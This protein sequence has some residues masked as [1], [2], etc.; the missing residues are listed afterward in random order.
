MSYAAMDWAQTEAP[1]TGMSKSTDRLVLIRLA[2]YFSEKTQVCW[3]S[4]G[5]LAIDL[6]LDKKTIRRALRRLEAA[7]LISQGP[8]RWVEHLEYTNRPTVWHLHTEIKRDNPRPRR[9]LRLSDPGD[10]VV[11]TPGD[12]V[13]LQTGN[14]EQVIRTG[15]ES[16]H[17]QTGTARVADPAP[18]ETFPDHCKAH[19]H[20]PPHEVPPCGGCQ[21]TREFNEA[22]ALKARAWELH[23]QQQEKLSLIHISEPT[24]P[25]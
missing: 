11:P 8:S 20:T 13:V 23:N 12:N 25:Y 3:P 1:I 19:R 10:N 15:G 18:L 9:R 24:R 14:Y 16:E 4:Q 22:S 6:D 7:G 5:R 21:K 17:E 2:H